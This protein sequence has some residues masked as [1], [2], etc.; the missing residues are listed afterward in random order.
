MSV[1]EVGRCCLELLKYK[2][3][4]IMEH[5]VMEVKH[6]EFKNNESYATKTH[7]TKSILQAND[8]SLLA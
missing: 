7:R 6:D 1:D 5:L 4:D 3:V 8:R 2:F